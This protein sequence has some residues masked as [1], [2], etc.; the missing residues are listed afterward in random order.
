MIGRCGTGGE[1]E[2]P[3][4]GRGGRRLGGRAGSGRRRQATGRGE[5]RV[6][7]TRGTTDTGGRR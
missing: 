7:S 3:L 4:V 5:S 2:R 6:G 1:R